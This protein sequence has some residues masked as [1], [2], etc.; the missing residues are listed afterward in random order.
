MK[1]VILF[2]LSIPFILLWIGGMLFGIVFIGGIF[3]L[4]I[5]ETWWVLPFLIVTIFSGCCF[6]I[7]LK[8]G[9]KQ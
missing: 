6:G 9:V 2:L 4:E 3:W 7:L 8:K 5:K 1:E